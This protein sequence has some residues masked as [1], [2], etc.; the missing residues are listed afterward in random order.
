M[1]QFQ[2]LFT[3]VIFFF[4]LSCNQEK[5]SVEKEDS[6]AAKKNL[7][8]SAI[9]TKAFD[10]GDTSMIDK[11]VASDFVDHTDRGDM[12]RDSLKAMIITM[13]KTFPD[14]KQEV[15]KELADDDYVFSMMRF[16]GTSEGQMGMPKGPYDMKAIEVVRYKDGMAVEHWTYME[17]REMMKM[18]APP[19]AK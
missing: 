8:V 11:V 6:S 12:G 19:E 9:I 2:L 15:I 17:P 3:P 10:T 18:M 14:M 16:T 13:R 4:L 1:K 7:E 5:V